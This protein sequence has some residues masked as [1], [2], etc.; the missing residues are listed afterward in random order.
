VI[1]IGRHRDQREI[2]ETQAHTSVEKRKAALS[3]QR[4]KSK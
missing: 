2:E 1:K 3:H 4:K